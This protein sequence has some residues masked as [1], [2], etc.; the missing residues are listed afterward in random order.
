MTDATSADRLGRF[1]ADLDY[2]QLPP[3]VVEHAKLCVLDTVG[4]GL[5]GA[6]LPWTQLVVE[7]TREI[8]NGADAGIWGTEE[9]RGAADAALVNGAAVHAF[10]LDDLHRRSIVHLG[11]V[12]VSAA[13]AAAEQRGGVSGRRL[14]AAI[15]AGYE[16]GARVGMSVGVRHL[17]DGWHPTGTHGAV[18]AGAAAAAV[19]EL[20][21]DQATAAL[22]LAATQ[23]GGLMAAQ[24]GSM[25]KR[26]HAGRAAQSGVYAAFL[27]R[28]GYTGI[29]NVFEA[30]YGGYGHTF[31]SA[32]DPSQLVAELDEKWETLA[33]GFK[34]YPANGSCHPTIDMLLE[35]RAD[36]IGV[37][38]VGR[39]DVHTSSATEKHVGWHYEPS[40]VTAAQM[41]LSYIAA[42]VLTD[43]EATVRQFS[44][45]RIHDPALVATSRL[46]HVTAD[47][48]IDALGDAHR[49]TTRVELTLLDGTTRTLTRRN[50]RGSLDQPLS[51]AELV[52]KFFDLA[53]SSVSD[54]RAGEIRDGIAALESVDDVRALGELLAVRSGE[55]R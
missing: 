2:N 23:A 3:A 51:S 8:G 4:C 9:R 10:E 32:F 1:V 43:G 34:P 47:P 15:V 26:F 18:A 22:G 49:H 5:Y 21:A 13:V 12:V 36:G 42:A 30:E 53:T 25:A 41:N 11:G 55:G 33:V 6:T 16:V 45:E 27:A 31:S 44:E 46:V 24:Y 19:L 52:R 28:L 7:M 14:V 54:K 37:G 35:L 50:A 29:E 17:L 48:D 40:S 38:A 39:I 20:D